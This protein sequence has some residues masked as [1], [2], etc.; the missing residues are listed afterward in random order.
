M[1]LFEKMPDGIKI[2]WLAFKT[3]VVLFAIF[4]A[5]NVTVLYQGF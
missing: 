2:F 3:A 5:T 4:H 1:H